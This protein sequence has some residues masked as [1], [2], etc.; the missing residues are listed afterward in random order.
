MS[1]QAIA[2][3]SFLILVTAVLLEIIRRQEKGQR[4]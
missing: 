2:I 1:I 3:I 4:K